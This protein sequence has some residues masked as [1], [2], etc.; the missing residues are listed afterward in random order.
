MGSAL[1][2]K[3]LYQRRCKAT[4][5][6]Q[7]HSILGIDKNCSDEDMKKAFRKLA[8][9]YHPDTP[10]GDARKFKDIN[11]AYSLMKAQR[12]KGTE[13]DPEEKYKST[14]TGS[15]RYTRHSTT[16]QDH[17]REETP[18]DIAES[19]SVIDICVIGAFTAVYVI[20]RVLYNQRRK[21][22]AKARQTLLEKF[23]AEGMPAEPIS[24]HIKDDAT[25]YREGL[26]EKRRKNKLTRF[27]DMR[28][29]FLVYDS[30]AARRKIDVITLGSEF[31]EEEAVLQA[32][33]IVAHID[34]LLDYNAY[35]RLLPALVDEVKKVP[36]KSVDTAPAV[37]TLLDGA[38]R[39][40]GV[41]PNNHRLTMFEYRDEEERDVFSAGGA[42]AALLPGTLVA[43]RCV[44]AIVND[45]YKPRDFTCR[46]QRLVVSGKR[47]QQPL[48]AAER[49]I[50]LRDGKLREED[51]AVGNPVP[52]KDLGEYMPTTKRH[53]RETK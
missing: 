46:N 45:R 29:Y 24:Q 28:E 15:R 5:I 7:P 10:T 32:C 19:L 9:Q 44:V 11:A 20:G 34:A 22:E 8:Q 23:Q 2:S 6:R 36:W 48:L 43:P 25:G 12:R 13:E 39:V 37:T 53:V 33:P 17:E 52:I 41:D 51:L 49:L 3:S 14:A 21:N 42:A 4:A 27:T 18:F 30:D 35:Q 31:L 50:A 16:A 1:S 40:K 47:T 38:A 26:L